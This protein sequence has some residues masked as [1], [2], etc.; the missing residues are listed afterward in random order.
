ME[1]AVKEVMAN[2][3]DLPIDAIGEST[4]PETVE[5]WDSLLQI[6]LVVALEDALE[7]EFDEEDLEKLV[8]YPAILEIVKSLKGR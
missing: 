2:V 8:G 6:N 1:Q 4:S 3:L 5:A 7:V